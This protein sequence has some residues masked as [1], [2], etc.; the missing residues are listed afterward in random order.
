MFIYKKQL[1]IENK[2]IVYAFV[3]IIVSNFLKDMFYKPTFYFK[4]FSFA[5]LCM[6]STI[7]YSQEVWTLE[8]CIQ[9]AWENNLNLK[10]GEINTK[11]A[12]ISIK[13]AKHARYPNLSASNDIYWNFGRTIDPTSNAFTTSTFFRNGIGVNTGATLFNGFAINNT[14]KQS[15]IDKVAVEEDLLQLKNDIGLE[16]ASY[17]LNALFAKENIVIAQSNLDLTGA[18]L[19]RTKS[20][21]QSGARPANEVLDIDAQIATDEQ[22]L[23]VAKN[24]Y[25]VAIMQLKQVMNTSE[26]FDVTPPS[27]ISLETNPEII[28]IDELYT[29]ALK[30]QHSVMADEQRVK[31]ADLG[32]KI[33]KGQ[34]Y[35]TINVGGNLGSNYSNQFLRVI[36]GNEDIIEQEIIFNGVRTSIGLPTFIP[37]TEK[38]PYFYQLD[39]NLSYGA[40]LSVNIPILTNYRTSGNIERAKLNRESAAIKYDNTKLALRL[41]VQS[42]LTDAQAALAKYEAAEKSLNAQQL[43]YDNTVKR[44]DIGAINAFDLSTAKTRL[45]NA[46]NNLLLAKYDNIFRN[47]ILDFYL[48]KALRF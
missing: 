35:P 39:K 25:T 1:F 40:G 34:L 30:T 15:K 7:N 38:A 23:I 6:I 10:T 11:S 17:Y 21:V 19:T 41:T 18:N 9:K 43:A 3:R 22:S 20:L 5:V 37:Q 14:L 33:A 4:I 31:S 24:N 16:V 2:N 48:G 27:N 46:K 44:F 28:T 45:D 13:I 42:A 32:I 8:Q 36:G 12:D 47:K 26:N 29:S